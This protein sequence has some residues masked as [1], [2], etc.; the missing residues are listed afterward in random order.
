MKRAEQLTRQQLEIIVDTIRYRL[1]LDIVDHRDAYTANKDLD[2][3][4]A[5]EAIRS[6]YER[7]GLA[8]GAAEEPVEND[9]SGVYVVFSPAVHDLGYGHGL[10]YDEA[11]AVADRLGNAC[12]IKVWGGED[13]EQDEADFPEGTDNED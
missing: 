9:R 11:V 8:P 1:F 10:P 3:D 12:I 7:H 2:L 6:L 13:P 5:I 4:E